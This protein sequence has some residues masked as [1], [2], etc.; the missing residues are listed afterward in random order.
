MKFLRR[1]LFVFLSFAVVCF[2]QAES[3]DGA[4]AGDSSVNA[5]LVKM[6]GIEQSP[7]EKQ[8]ALEQGKDRA[9]LCFR[10]HGDDGNSLRD[11]IP[12]LASQ[13]AAYLFTQFEK[14]ANGQRE[15][16]VM[17]KVAPSLTT[18]ERIAIAVY[19]ADK[20]VLSRAQGVMPDTKG[21]M[22]YDSLCYVCHGTAGHGDQQYPRIA[23]QPYVF[24]EKTLLSF[25][26]NDPQRRNSPMT[27]VIQNLTEEDLKAVAA[28]VSNLP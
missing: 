15:N 2:A 6:Q 14:F 8:A 19:F 16:Y 1:C 25:K 5:M 26:N 18:D 21:K 20:P 27:G 4:T 13:N 10:C 28:W 3:S 11:Y 9:L 12:N 22:V 24:L 7:L 23:G 17:S